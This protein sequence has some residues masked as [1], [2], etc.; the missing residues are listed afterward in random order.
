[1][2]KDGIKMAEDEIAPKKMKVKE[3]VGICGDGIVTD[4]EAC[5]D[6]NQDN[7]D[8]CDS[9]C[10]VERGWSCA[11]GSAKHQ[12]VCDRCGNGI[13]AGQEQCDDGNRKDGDGCNL[14]CR[15]EPG[16]TCQQKF[17]TEKSAVVSVCESTVTKANNLM[18][19]FNL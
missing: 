3:P 5:D 7:G 9:Q 18:K 15:E 16:F 10:R 17:S 11:G 2:V 8:G 1:M 14:L 4:G 6:L 12:S 13:V 19:E